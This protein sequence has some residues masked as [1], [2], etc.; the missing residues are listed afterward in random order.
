MLCHTFLLS[1]ALFTEPRPSLC[2]I[3]VDLNF[4]CVLWPNNKMMNWVS[5]PNPVT[6][7]NT[8]NIQLSYFCVIPLNL[9]WPAQYELSLHD[10]TEEGQQWKSFGSLVKVRLLKIFLKGIF[11]FRN[12]NHSPATQIRTG[13]MKY[14]FWHVLTTKCTWFH[15]K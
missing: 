3:K 11:K 15:S 2:H 12:L 8:W 9:R 4:L 10:S 7:L 5:A 1:P 6:Q 14:I 13:N